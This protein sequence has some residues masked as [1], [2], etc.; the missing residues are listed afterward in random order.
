[1]RRA[2][3]WLLLALC[4]ASP[5]A[6]AGQFLALS[7]IHFDPMA[8]PSLVDRLNA[9]APEDWAKIF[10]SSSDKSLG[11]YGRDTDWP[12][13]SSALSAMK[14][15]LPHPDFVVMTGDFLAH[16]FRVHFDLTAR[17]HSDAAYRAFIERTM[18]FLALQLERAFP[19]TPILPVLGNNDSYCGDYRLTPGGAFLKD[20][21][22]TMRGLLGGAAGAGF[23]GH[24]RGLGNYAV[25]LP[26]LPHV[27]VAGLDTVFFSAHYSAAC[28]GAAKG[29]PGKASLAW[30][31]GTLAAAR[32][33]HE[34]VWLLYHVPP[35]ID[36]YATA[37]FGAC[38]QNIV[39]LWQP[40]YQ[41]AFAA[42][43]KEYADTIAASLA[44]HLHT[45]A[46]RLADRTALTLVIPAI[47]PIF[48]ENPGFKTISYD[49][50]GRLDDATTYELPSL[51][52]GAAW[53]EEYRFTS[54]WRL[55][56]L[57]LASL[58]RL[59]RRI[60]GEPR[61]RARWLSLYA[62]SNASFWPAEAAERAKRSRAAY[63]A[64]GHLSATGFATCYC[65]AS[66]NK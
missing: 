33:A 61:T 4:A 42:L 40:A 25:R 15:A 13:L 66:G 63:C 16:S 9:A 2:L 35:G 12:L 51:S 48:G 65:P 44:G 29:D 32:R 54:E 37:R 58:D 26:R 1:M 7:D 43:L 17:N 62:L 24:W 5:A 64:G 36:D 55:P 56:R 11:R 30:L 50:A 45:D 31:A 19:K 3:L 18:R 8:D 60:G 22:P 10:A 57:D 41:T 14:E 59:Y 6:A 28:A 27:R 47:S 23:A 52:G 46:F 21:E 38:P 49:S 53:V 34:R 20:V 39:P